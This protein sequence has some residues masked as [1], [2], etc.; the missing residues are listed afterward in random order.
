MLEQHTTDILDHSLMHAEVDNN[1]SNDIEA[2]LKNLS[3][4]VAQLAIHNQSDKFKQMSMPA[5]DFFNKKFNQV[6]QKL[7]LLSETNKEKITVYSSKLLTITKQLVT[8][9]GSNSIADEWVELVITLCQEI[10]LENKLF[11]QKNIYSDFF[12]MVKSILVKTIELIVTHYHDRDQQLQYNLKTLFQYVDCFEQ[13]QKYVGKLKLE[14]DLFI[15]KDYAKIYY[16]TKLQ[17]YAAAKRWNDYFS[18]LMEYANYALEVRLPLSELETI[19]QKLFE[20]Y[21]LLTQKEKIRNV[22]K[23]IKFFKKSTGDEALQT[24]LD[25]VALMFSIYIYRLMLID[26]SLQKDSNLNKFVKQITLSIINHQQFNTYLVSM[27]K[28]A[29]VLDQKD[30]W[31]FFVARFLINQ[32]DFISNEN[33]KGEKILAYIHIF[34]HIKSIS[35]EKFFNQEEKEQLKQERS[36]LEKYFK[37]C[38]SNDHCTVQNN[39]AH[40]LEWFFEEESVASI[41]LFRSY[42]TP[43]FNL[44]EVGKNSRK[45]TEERLQALYVRFEK[46]FY[47]HLEQYQNKKDIKLLTKFS[48][49]YKFWAEVFSEMVKTIRTFD[50]GYLAKITQIKSKLE[51]FCFS[52][53]EAICEYYGITFVIE[54]DLRELSVENFSSKSSKL[55]E[56]IKVQEECQSAILKLKICNLLSEAKASRLNAIISKYDS[57][58]LIESFNNQYNNST[59]K[60]VAWRNETNFEQDFKLSV[61]AIEVVNDAIL[62]LEHL[63]AVDSKINS[64]FLQLKKDAILVIA[65]LFPSSQKLIEHGQSVLMLI[66]NLAQSELEEIYSK[67]QTDLDTVVEILK[68]HWERKIFD[69]N[70][71]NELSEQITTICNALKSVAN[72][73]DLFSYSYT[74]IIE[75]QL[76]LYRVQSKIDANKLDFKQLNSLYSGKDK[77]LW[78][79]VALWLNEA[80]Q[81]QLNN[82]VLQDFNT[83]L[84][85]TESK[86][87]KPQKIEYFVSLGIVFEIMRLTKNLV[88]KSI[89]KKCENLVTSYLEYN[90]VIDYL[91][92]LHE[93]YQAS[94]KTYPKI[95]LLKQYIDTIVV[96]QGLNHQFCFLFPEKLTTFNR[97]L[98]K[99]EYITD[100]W[101]LPIIE[102]FAE[103]QS[104]KA[105]N[106]LT[107]LLSDLTNIKNEIYS[108]YFYVNN[109]KSLEKQLVRVINLAET[110]ILGSLYLKNKNVSL[111]TLANNLIANIRAVG[112]IIECVQ[113]TAITNTAVIQKYLFDLYQKLIIV[114]RIVNIVLNDDAVFEL[115]EIA[116]FIHEYINI[117]DLNSKKFLTHSELEKFLMEEKTNN[118]LSEISCVKRY[119]Y[120]LLLAAHL[121]DYKK[122]LESI[123]RLIGRLNDKSVSEVDK[124]DLEQM[125][126]FVSECIFNNVKHISANK[127][128][129][130]V[131]QDIIDLF[132][133]F[134]YI[135]PT[136]T[137]IADIFLQVFYELSLK[138]NAIIDEKLKNK[139]LWLIDDYCK[140]NI[141]QNIVTL[142]DRKN[143]PNAVDERL[144]EL[145]PFYFNKFLIHVENPK[146]QSSAI[147][148]LL[149]AYINLIIRQRLDIKKAIK[150][151][152]LTDDCRRFITIFEQH[153]IYMW[154]ASH[155]EYL[156]EQL[157]HG[158]T[159]DVGSYLHCLEKL[160]GYCSS[161]LFQANQ[162][163]LNILK[164]K[165]QEYLL[166]IIE[167][168]KQCSKNQDEISFYK[169]LNHYN[170]H[171]N[172]NKIYAFI[173]RITALEN[174][175][176]KSRAEQDQA[177]II[178][179]NDMFVSLVTNISDKVVAEN[180]L[181]KSN[182]VYQSQNTIPT[183]D[184][185]D[186]A[187][188]EVDNYCFSLKNYYA[189]IHNIKDAYQKLEAVNKQNDVVELL[190]NTTN[191]LNDFNVIANNMFR[192]YASYLLYLK[193]KLFDHVDSSIT[194]KRSQIEK[195]LAIIVADVK[196]INA[197]V[198]HIKKLNNP[199]SCVTYFD[200]VLQFMRDLKIFMSNNKLK[201]DTIEI[202]FWVD[203]VSNIWELLKSKNFSIHCYHDFIDIFN[204]TINRMSEKDEWANK[205]LTLKITV[206][207]DLQKLNERYANN[208]LTFLKLKLSLFVY[209]PYSTNI[210]NYL[211]NYLSLIRNN[212]LIVQ[213]EDTQNLLQCMVSE[214][215]LKNIFFSRDKEI[216]VDAIY[217]F[218]NILDELTKQEF[219]HYFFMRIY[220]KIMT[221]LCKLLN[222]FTTDDAEKLYDSLV[223]KFQEFIG[224]YALAMLNLLEIDLQLQEPTFQLFLLTMI[225]KIPAELSIVDKSRI[226]ILWNKS[227]MSLSV[228]QRQ[229]YMISTD[230]I[231][232]L[233]NQSLIRFLYDKIKKLNTIILPQ[234]SKQLILDDIANNITEYRQLFLLVS[235]LKE[236]HSAE[237]MSPLNLCD[238]LSNVDWEKL[239]VCYDEF[240]A[241]LIKQ[242]PT[243]K[244]KLEIIEKMLAKLDSFILKTKDE[245]EQ[246]ATELLVE[247]SDFLANLSQEAL[248]YDM[249]CLIAFVSK[250]MECKL[251]N[252]LKSRQREI[253]ESL[254]NFKENLVAKCCNWALLP[255][256]GFDFLIQILARSH[257]LIEINSQNETIIIP[258]LLSRILQAWVL[259][260]PINLE[261]LIKYLLDINSADFNIDLTVKLIA[262][263]CQLFSSKTHSAELTKIKWDEVAFKVFNIFQMS[264][265]A[266]STTTFLGVLIKQNSLLS[267][268]SSTTL[269]E[270]G[271]SKQIAKK[272]NSTAL[273]HSIT[274]SASLQL[275]VDTQSEQ[276]ALPDVLEIFKRDLLKYQIDIE[277]NLLPLLAIMVQLDK[278][279]NLENINPTAKINQLKQQLA[280]CFTQI[281][282]YFVE[283]N[284]SLIKLNDQSAFEQ[285]LAWIRQ[286]FERMTQLENIIK[287][288]PQMSEAFKTKLKTVINKQQNLIHDALLNINDYLNNIVQNNKNI[289]SQHLKGHNSRTA[290]S[291]R[292]VEKL[293]QVSKKILAD[294]SLYQKTLS[295]YPDIKL[296][297]RERVANQCCLDDFAKTYDNITK[298]C[299]GNLITPYSASILFF[300]P[301]VPNT[302]SEANEVQLTSKVE[303]LKLSFPG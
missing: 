254:N 269:L 197:H 134:N 96:V 193:M 48:I 84:T 298:I 154:L 42:I 219:Y 195:L 273:T 78:L 236:L 58:S 253:K 265:I 180:D 43:I 22:P 125:S 255:E 104:N 210:V 191:T 76:M 229:N 44:K 126:V 165:I 268:D 36:A 107:N 39:F 54:H 278:K 222:K 131:L 139:C 252:F 75:L 169:A 49:K 135:V 144:L 57:S 158:V 41:E 216:K 232:S 174:I 281:T 279:L 128:S 27:F 7:N 50:E 168:I 30:N 31:I 152:K 234:A 231:S 13:L 280:D 177:L 66:A 286:Q 171:I 292:Q 143:E 204:S 26:V 290:L 112:E 294:L 105:S 287:F 288:Y 92:T 183:Y 153:N 88:D 136:N 5:V 23:L 261:K 18:F 274:Q 211:K 8:E 91:K 161:Q 70:N 63:P 179:I 11:D 159:L 9:L 172:L 237:I 74:K 299:N 166:E 24:I 240:F 111:Q 194:Y 45:N 262:V 80:S 155:I 160:C 147:N 102:Y 206:A 173:E 215:F 72:F 127:L 2:L 93:D 115:C 218:V 214:N 259:S 89:Y 12:K 163:D 248:L 167:N 184:V 233:M 156:Y 138:I 67:L 182:K 178:I 150:D 1:L 94:L 291:K 247:L 257:P 40:L 192:G 241:A 146:N 68:C 213:Y 103:R 87:Y 33:N 198:N 250:L 205:F 77:L 83:I 142:A 64:K 108:C 175:A 267:N 100:N 21:C 189:K 14:A 293:Q 220:L 61:N 270:N 56:F 137:K 300:T 242:D 51:E 20:T 266:K 275:S 98:E 119:C 199:D 244:A 35:L 117:D 109:E 303:S 200:T 59:S 62:Q 187:S 208:K 209:P 106:G 114:L 25:R 38:N 34:N 202:D 157:K 116:G 176:H 71:L 217:D 86:T 99:L 73:D 10:I 46:S 201:I 82:T 110:S 19:C 260:K 188:L 227:C 224:K 258:E 226:C 132:I 256:L 130:T 90:N 149:Y 55:L 97:I 295:H 69:E 228:K 282:N 238:S 285:Q 207:N 148:K 283:F 60:Y 16:Q 3:D 151:V 133:N 29:I 124:L 162:L 271:Q 235:K 120:Q 170:L 230:L 245:K 251:E 123:K 212:L 118:N 264:K 113:I 101:Q 203:I 181:L 289:I 15:E 301:P 141:I 65:N 81:M 246:A 302:S 249:E 196:I 121:T 272:S 221:G 225:S 79:S 277:T 223:S 32:F 263:S 185:Y 6:L 28:K 17:F 47:E 239:L 85:L 190:N 52:R 243:Q 276:N 4:S 129:D 37:Q 296:A 95:T 186:I 140:K 164:Q 297:I 53:L 122:C 284:V 145:Y